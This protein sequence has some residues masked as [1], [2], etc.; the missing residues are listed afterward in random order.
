MQADGIDRLS[1]TV[2]SLHAHVSDDWTTKRVL[3]IL[4]EDRAKV[5]AQVATRLH[6][7]ELANGSKEEALAISV[8]QRLP[9]SPAS[10]QIHRSSTRCREF[11]DTA[12]TMPFTSQRALKRRLKQPPS[13][14]WQVAVHRFPIGVLTIFTRDTSIS[15]EQEGPKSR[16]QQK[17]WSMTVT[18]FPVR[19]IA[20]RAL[21]LSIVSRFPSFGAPSLTWSL[22]QAAYND[23]SQLLRCL[24]YCDVDGLIALFQSTRARPTDIIAPWGNSLLHV[25][26]LIQLKRRH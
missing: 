22:D 25:C 11:D 5:R 24:K 2:Q 21:Q 7:L 12:A 8:L 15:N 3:D 6:D 13:V 20:Q 10:M 26:Y 19:W 14:S 18:L 23:D 4:E 9:L 1:R 17:S 16:S